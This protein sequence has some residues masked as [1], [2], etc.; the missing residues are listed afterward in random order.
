MKKYNILIVDDE[1]I[2][3]GWIGLMLERGLQQAVSV[4]MA[5]SGE[6]AVEMLSQRSYDIVITDIKMKRMDGLELI[7]HIKELCPGAKCILIS[8]YG[9]FS[10][11]KEA[12]LL[13]ASNYLLKSE[14]NE[15]DLIA[16]TK[17]VIEE[18]NLSR[19]SMESTPAQ[20][21][22]RGGLR[23]LLDGGAPDT[24]DTALLEKLG[25]D[26]AAYAIA[27]FELDFKPSD[28]DYEETVECVR[29]NIQLWFPDSPCVRRDK[30]IVAFLLA[31]STSLKTVREQLEAF[32]LRC[33]AESKHAISAG[34]S[35]LFYTLCDVNSSFRS[36]QQALEQRYF[37]TGR[38]VRFYVDHPVHSADNSSQEIIELHKMLREIHDLLNLQ[39]IEL[40][41]NK[42][43]ELL[44][45]YAKT[46]HLT[47]REAVSCMKK[48]RS[49]F[50]DSLIRSGNTDMI[51]ENNNFDENIEQFVLYCEATEYITNEISNI[52]K[53]CVS[54]PRPDIVEATLEYVQRNFRE[55]IS[56]AQVAAGLYVSEGYLSRT[57]SK[58][59]GKTFSTYLV[60]IRISASKE[61]LRTNDMS[62]SQIGSTVGFSSMS[63]YAQAF[64]KNEGLS[65]RE[66]RAKYSEI[67]KK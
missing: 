51:W 45:V 65:P 30:T 15:D 55:N 3:R 28:E 35:P 37:S 8:N 67:G 13:G 57:F 24:E 4:D 53:L 43:Y 54:S 25:K 63:Y 66:W 60:E 42:S 9:E 27:V 40:A 32:A 59:I 38:C 21:R 10:Y 52:V 7:A 61:M 29:K 19:R 33:I 39:Q 56:L 14:I 34:I 26:A 41:L 2:I 64:R 47:R 6:E 11:A 1:Y 20:L 58:K 22:H 18:I 12:M 48:L 50:V 16:V 44:E 17:K 23:R 46:V 5:A 36:A 62:I 49:F 31:R